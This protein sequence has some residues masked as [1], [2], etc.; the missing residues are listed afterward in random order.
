M[1][2]LKKPKKE[3]YPW[4]AEYILADGKKLIGKIRPIYQIPAGMAEGNEIH[5]RVKDVTSQKIE[6]TW[7]EMEGKAPSNN[8]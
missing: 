7:I 1:R 2:L 8:K 4:E 5:L 3:K 6:F